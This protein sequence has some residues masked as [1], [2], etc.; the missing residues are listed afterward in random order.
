MGPGQRA[1][2][3]YRRT[4]RPV[5]RDWK[6]VADGDVNLSLH[7]ARSS[8]NTRHGDDQRQAGDHQF[9]KKF[10]A[11]F[12]SRGCY[13]FFFAGGANIASLIG[14]TGSSALATLTGTGNLHRFGGRHSASLH[15]CTTTVPVR[16]S[17]RTAAVAGTSSC[18]L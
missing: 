2:E 8:H 5:D 11:R 4:G 10:H 1:A 13:F 12:L 7:E 18:P 16:S 9:A 6:R 3:T 17:R 14:L 15:A